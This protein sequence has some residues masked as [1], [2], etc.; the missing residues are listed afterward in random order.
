[1]HGTIEEIADAASDDGRT[2]LQ[3]H[4]RFSLFVPA[5]LV[6]DDCELPCTLHNIS[7]G[8]AKIRT[9]TALARGAALTLQIDAYSLPGE[10]VWSQGEFAGIGFHQDPEDVQHL[11]ETELLELPSR[12][13]RRAHRR[14]S[15]LMTGTLFIDGQP[16]ACVV[17]NVSLGG[18]RVACEGPLGED[19]GV[20]LE[21][22]R[23]GMFP[24]RVV[25]EHAG[26][27]GLC[28]A[29]PPSQ[30]AAMVGD[31]LPRCVSDS[32]EVPP[33]PMAAAGGER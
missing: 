31:V 32:E 24:A 8:G 19:R 3:Q 15:V 26:D 23:F 18:A 13:E 33:R 12:L 29:I 10:V 4:T 16:Y 22:R 25:W 1:V 5:T 20:V 28:F 17:K 27:Y 6:A 2:D 11:I 30:V 7:A 14:C 9:N 21:V